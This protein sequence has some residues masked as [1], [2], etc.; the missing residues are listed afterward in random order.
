MKEVK[1]RSDQMEPNIPK[2]LKLVP[3]KFLLC[4]AASKR[5]KQIKEGVKPYIGLEGDALDYPINV[6]LKEIEKSKIKIVVKEKPV[7]DNHVLD[8]MD[9]VLDSEIAVAAAEAAQADPEKKASVKEKGKSKF[10][11]LAA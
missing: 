5:S 4:I 9:Q 1:Y 10:R 8:E 3:N 2:L 7:D 11:S 6:A